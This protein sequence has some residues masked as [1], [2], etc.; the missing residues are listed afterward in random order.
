MPSQSVTIHELIRSGVRFTWQEAVALT[1]GVAAASSACVPR[2][3]SSNSILKHF[4]LHED[5][6]VEADTECAAAS[7]AGLAMFLGR[8][9]PA[10]P[11]DPALR[12]PSG[13]HYTIG[14]ALGLVQSTPFAS[15]GHFSEV[16]ARYEQGNRQSVLRDVFDRYRAACDACS[17]AALA[18]GDE[19]RGTSPRPDTL[20]RLLRDADQEAW[21]SG[22]RGQAPQWRARRQGPEAEMLRRFLREADRRNYELSR[23]VTVGARRRSIAARG[24]AGISRVAR[25]TVPLNRAARVASLWSRNR[26]AAGFV[27]LFLAGGAAAERRPIGHAWSGLIASLDFTSSRPAGAIATTGTA[28]AHPTD[29][30]AAGAVQQGDI[31]PTPT[32]HMPGGAAVMPS[33]SAEANPNL[34]DTG[35]ERDADAR[36]VEPFSALTSS[37]GR[38]IEALDVAQHP[39]FSS[40]FAA[41]RAILFDNDAQPAGEAA[42]A[43]NFVRVLSIADDRGR[44]YHPRLSPDGTTIA[45]D[46][47]RDGARGV[48]LASRDGR[49]V[50][51]ISGPEQYA[52]FPAWS[53]DGNHV[54]FVQSEPEQPTVWNVW[55]ADVRSDVLARLT[56]FRDGQPWGVS[57]FPDGN[58]LCFA[59]EQVLVVLDTTTGDARTFASPRPGKLVRMPVV[60]PDGSRIIFQ[61]ANDGAWLL[62]MSDGSM[63]QVLADPSVE[64]CAW[65]RDGKQIVFRTRDGGE[66]T[67]WSLAPEG[68]K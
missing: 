10:E 31:R 22:R 26:V 19:R 41:D 27:I 12:P 8:L 33:G 52:A 59:H 18:P 29:A 61:I 66:W 64:E 16:L 62:E 55:S 3:T 46:S 25:A 9:L 40:S 20:R 51:R 17:T 28:A 36:P 48:Y 11:L 34:A 42:P 65:S 49:H 58:R 1:Q 43:P 5:G 32:P 2:V 60:S 57:W 45:F 54:A 35:G 63:R 39:V 44:N 7:V 24:F 15:L 6:S 13:V 23:R 53:P 37:S 67:S 68:D 14:R 56:W 21:F 38:M 50:R 4:A 30:R 47:D